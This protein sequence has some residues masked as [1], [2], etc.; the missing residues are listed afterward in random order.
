MGAGLLPVSARAALNLV[1]NFPVTNGQ[2]YAI[3]STA[4]DV[5]VGGNFTVAGRHSGNGAIVDQS[6]GQVQ[7]GGVLL[8]GGVNVAVSDTAGGFYVGGSITVDGVS[9]GSLIHILSSGALDPAFNAQ[10][11]GLVTSLALDGA[12]GF[13]YVGGTFSSMGGQPRSNLA[14]INSGTGTADLS[15]N[16]AANATVS[17]LLLDSA[18]GLLVG[19]A[20]T[21]VAGVPRTRTAKVTTGGILDGGFLCDVNAQVN[22]LQMNGGALYLGGT[23]T[24][25]NGITR[26]RV[27]KVNA[28]SGA[29]DPL[30]NCSAS[31]TVNALAFD[32]FNNLY[33]GGAFTTVSGVART[34]VARVDSGS[35]VTDQAFNAGGSG[36]VSCLAVDGFGSLTV[37]GTFQSM[38]FNNRSNLARIDVNTGFADSW[39]PSPELAVKAVAVNDGFGLVFIGGAF[40]M[41]ESVTRNNLFKFNA[42]TG[43]IDPLFNPGPNLPVHALAPLGANLFIGGEFNF[44]G[45]QSRSGTAKMLTST[46]AVDAT[47]LTGS[48]AGSYVLALVPDATGANLYAGGE[49]TAIGGQVRN[50][51]AKLDVFTGAAN[52]NFDANANVAVESLAYDPAGFLYAGGGFSAIGGQSRTGV[53]KLLTYTGL[54]DPAFN[55]A[56]PSGSVKSLG[57]DG[58]NLYLGGAF[59]TAGG[60][61][62]NNAAKVLTST[63]S[64]VLAY[65]ANAAPGAVAAMAFGPAMQYLGGTFAALGASSRSSVGKVDSATG[66]VDPQFNPNA[67]GF[68]VSS[69]NYSPQ[70]NHLYLGG[71][72]TALGGYPQPYFAVLDESLAA[73]ATSTPTITPTLTPSP[74]PTGTPVCACLL[75]AGTA[76][77]GG[78]SLDFGGYIHAN[79]YILPMGSNHTLR[80]VRV[81][82]RVAGGGQ[83]RAA[84]Y[85]AAGM[86]HSFLV[87]SAPQVAVLG[88]NNLDIPD[89]AAFGG[90]Q[91]LIALMTGPGVEVA[92]SVGATGNEHVISQAS[93]PFGAFPQPILSTDLG[94]NPNFYSATVDFCPDTCLTPTETP[95]YSA[96]PSPTE[97]STSTISPSPSPTFTSTISPSPSFS[98]TVSPSPSVTATFTALPACGWGAGEQADVVLGQPDFTA[99]TPNNG[100]VNAASLNFPGAALVVGGKLLV[101]EYGNNRILIY[102]SIP[103]SP[104]APADVVIGQ[105]DFTTTSP[106]ISSTKLNQPFAL[107]SDGT[108]LAVADRGNHRVLIYNSIPTVS[109]AAANRVLGQPSFTIGT[110]N[111]GG[112][113]ASSL[114]LPMGLAFTGGGLAI[115][116]NGNHR[117]KVHFSVPGVDN[118]PADAVI[119]QPGFGVGT[120]NNGGVT[121]AS[122]NSP[123]GVSSDGTGLQIADSNNN[124]VL[125][126]NTV[127]AVNGASAD[128]V[129]GQAAFNST[130][131]GTTQSTLATPFGLLRLNAGLLVADRNN[132]RVLLFDPLPTANGALAASVVGQANF[133]SSGNG[134]GP[135]SFSAPGQPAA[136]GSK[137]VVPDFNNHRVL[138]FECGVVYSPTVTPSPSITQ[139]ST[140]TETPTFSSTATPS[141]TPTATETFTSTAS[142]SGT[143]SPSPSRT[144]T[145]TFSASPSITVSFTPVPAAVWLGCQWSHRVK[146]TVN[147]AM[148]SGSLG[149]FPVF[150]KL[151][152]ASLGSRARSDG[153]DLRFTDADGVTPLAFEVEQW[154]PGAGNL[155]AW[156][157]LPSLYAGVNHDLY[158]YYGNPAAADGQNPAGV[159]DASYEAVYH[160]QNGGPDSGPSARTAA[161]AGATPVAGQLA[162]GQDFF[163]GAHLDAGAWNVAGSQMSMQAWVWFDAFTLQDE[164]VLSKA[165][166]EADEDH[167]FMLSAVGSGQPR[168][169]FKTGASDFSGTLTLPGPTVMSTGQWHLM[170]GTYDGAMARLYLDG[171]LEASAPLTGALRNN[172]WS[173]YLGANP[174]P[175]AHALDGRLDEVRVSNQARSG[176]WLATEYANQSN[177][178]AFLAFGA[179]EASGCATPTVSASFTPTVSP[180]FSATV[181]STFTGTVTGTFTSSATPSATR[182]VTET[183]TPSVTPSSS[184]TLTATR[185][186]TETSTPSATPT[187]TRTVTETS[188]ASVTAT[189]TRTVTVSATPS[190]TRTQT[191]LPSPS[192]SPVDSATPTATLTPTPYL[193]STPSVTVSLTPSIT[194][195]WTVSDTPVPT[196]TPVVPAVLSQNVFHPGGG[197]PLRIGIKAPEDGRVVVNVFNM[198]GEKV[199]R[200]F[201][202]EV[203]AGQTMEAVWDGTNEFGEPCGSGVYLVS[204][205]GAGIRRVLKVILLK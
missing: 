10:G 42:V 8:G 75:Q 51:L 129:I 144:V 117:V 168:L 137:L 36:T 134:T 55:A 104:N 94:G 49:F 28:L 44:V 19:G 111:N 33:L 200:P 179:E 41:L 78:S 205:K 114:N 182:T 151:D 160:L 53:A 64:A 58:V 173:V 194:T 180:T 132:N 12:S 43:A 80:G 97:S 106:G 157:S 172:A 71:Q 65:D 113:S 74:T 50:R 14:K 63:G 7:P 135:A 86:N 127:P 37:G 158:L 27:A 35:G 110:A 159:W 47:Y 156:V 116:D 164:R 48:W 96:S 199:R 112:L 22:A 201:E 190:V 136:W 149:A 178:G 107:A 128:V 99:A 139:T 184:V 76:G 175:Q 57:F 61:T 121:A 31:S 145:G 204:I 141:F 98:A 13:L 138:V 82:V 189:P 103:V 26:N 153:F 29:L 54:A 140:S 88:W 123:A 84:I 108:R 167:V 185:T 16:L 92:Y 95:S 72:F 5:F 30:F 152:D 24:T 174:G 93:Q 142:P 102:N 147:G 68:L 118:A 202:A 119:G 101:A 4:T 90:Q 56:I 67:G 11:S 163:G 21:T 125:L 15:F 120:A 39:N 105:P 70:T 87:Q 115:A 1:P 79:R 81:N 109:G 6:S 126:F 195:T 32:N 177:P 122:L 77:V 89:V 69:V 150:V 25:V 23:F 154:T 52:V 85:Q 73:T 60:Q 34:A 66:V 188:T 186:I 155:R 203:P 197:Q 181:T 9:K 183:S 100:G 59:S 143:P 131:G 187:A 166:N 176:A 2:V 130:G 165:V 3:S 133:I 169:R 193:S 83:I 91:I 171:A 192:F 196:G 62:R 146:V 124:R 198:A 170:A 148:V 17:A 191:P 18:G 46:G 38:G 161:S 20:F 40:N 45:G 162:G